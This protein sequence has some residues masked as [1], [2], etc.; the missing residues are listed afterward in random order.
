MKME[1]QVM[2]FS[3]AWDQRNA[4]ISDALHRAA[5]G[6]SAESAPGDEPLAVS[7]D[8]RGRERRPYLRPVIENS[9]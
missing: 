2:W 4:R 5:C 1:G 8:G 6:V 7:S 9:L 3:P